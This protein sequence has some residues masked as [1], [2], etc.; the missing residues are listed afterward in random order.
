[1]LS[2]KKEPGKRFQKLD[3]TGS[4]EALFHLSCLFFFLFLGKSVS[5]A[6][7]PL[8]ERYCASDSRLRSSET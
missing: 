8:I 5:F 2:K 1:M 7:M 6:L 4:R 3:R